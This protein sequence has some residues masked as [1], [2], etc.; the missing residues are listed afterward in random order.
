MTISQFFIGDRLVG[1]GAPCLIIA[2]VGL[3][4]DGSL[5]AAYAYIDAAAEAGADAVKF[6]THIAEAESSPQEQF[7]VKV[8]PQDKT[9]YEYWERTAFT[10]EQWRSLKD[11]AEKKNL[12]FLSTPF[13]NAA[14]T[15]QIDCVLMNDSHEAMAKTVGLSVVEHATYFQWRKPDLLLIVG[16][17]F[18]ML[19]P[20]VA[21]SMM[22]IPIAH[23]QGGEISGTIDNVIRDVITRF[24]SLHFVS[25]EKSALNLIRYN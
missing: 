1:E 15:Q 20:A 24:A 21:A 23:I 14:V 6:Q 3:A 22:N 10:V 13:S 25:T 12:I 4:H 5:G 11:Y 9:R 16:D 7:R 2:E 8:F 19:A 18:D 17:R